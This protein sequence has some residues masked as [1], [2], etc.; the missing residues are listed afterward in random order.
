MSISPETGVTGVVAGPALPSTPTQLFIGGTWRD[1]VRRRDVRRHLPDERAG[2]RARSRPRRAEDVDAA[3]ARRAAQVD[4]GEWASM[5][6]ADR[7]RLLYR[8]AD[9]D[10]ARPRDVRD[11]RG[12]RRRQAGVRAAHGRHPERD[13][14]DPPLRGL[15]RQDRGSL[16][17]A[18]ADL[19]PRAP[20]V[21]DPRAARRDRRDHRLERADAD[22]V[23]EARPGAR[24]R[25]RRRAQA[26]GG[27]A[28]DLAAPRGAD[29]GGRA[30]RRASSTSPG[31]RRDAGAALVRH[32]GV[33]KISFTGS[34]EV[35]REIA[36]Q[37]ARDFRRV[38]LELGGK[39]P[40]IVL[41]DADLERRRSRASPIGFLANQGEIC[42]AGTRILVA[43]EHYDDVV[44]GPR[45]RGAR[46]APRRPVRPAT[47]RWAR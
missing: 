23:L 31:P 2:P 33:D 6:G 17:D 22:R 16:G 20:G 15:G 25:Q 45:R 41:A 19:R 32:P 47:R 27:R 28:A 39:S 13:R 44:S 36:V 3:V 34:P 37:A 35:G 40:Q 1:A 7:G 14:H 26:G 4:G 46:R 18:A 8:L 9:A 5:T 21:H 11:A 24:R 29:R 42:A 12:L 38:T 43:R 30:S 10:R